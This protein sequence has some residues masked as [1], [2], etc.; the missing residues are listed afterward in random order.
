MST[1]YE[2]TQN[3]FQK[4]IID[5]ERRQ[6]YRNQIVELN[7]RLVNHILKKYKPYTEDQYQVGCIGL[8]LAVD[9]FKE[10]KGVPFAN[11]ACFCIERELHKLNRYQN[12]LIEFTESDRFL[13]LDAKCITKSGEEFKVSERIADIRASEDFEQLLGEY[14]LVNL[15]DEVIKPA[16]NHVGAHNKSQ[17]LKIDIEVWKELEL[18]YLLEISQG[19]QKMRFNLSQMAKYLKT[20]VQN[21]RTR[22]LRVIQYIKKTCKREGFKE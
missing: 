12:T 2:R 14:D 11:Y 13:C 9:T 6:I 18:R 21:V 16:I 15:F 17:K 1:Y 7:L 4:I 22:H 8:V 10:D 20:S 19:S 5:P 3:L